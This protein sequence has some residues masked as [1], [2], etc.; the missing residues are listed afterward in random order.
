MYSCDG[1]TVVQVMQSIVPKRPM[2]DASRGGENVE[3]TLRDG[4]FQMTM[5][6]GEPFRFAIV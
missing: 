4:F 2:Q 6:T 5:A 1:E 3:M